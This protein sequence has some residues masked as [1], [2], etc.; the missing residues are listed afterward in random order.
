MLKNA[1][2]SIRHR[3]RLE[4]L[5]QMKGLLK[6]ASSDKVLEVGIADREYSPVDNFLIKAYPWQEKITALGVGEVSGFRKLY[7]N[8]RAVSYNGRI[9]PFKT[10]EFDIVHSNAVIEHVGGN[11]EQEL[12]LREMARV[13]KRGMLTTP[14]RHF[15]IETHTRVPFLHWI[16]KKEFDKILIRIG[17]GWAA[18]PYMHLLCERDLRALAEKVRL[19][20][21]RI[22]KNR[23]FGLTMT[24]TLIWFND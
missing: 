10:N 4:K 11:K 7:P 5:E 8:V 19:R 6:A 12:F 1:V 2:N 16:G 17:K 18:G 23:L 20:N 13:A 14:N 22:I 24:F 9:F 3:S 21:Y 15:P